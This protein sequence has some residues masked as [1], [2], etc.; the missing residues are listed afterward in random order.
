MTS[1]VQ[2]A[3]ND[4]ASKKDASKSTKDSQDKDGLTAVPLRIPQ[5]AQP[6]AKPPIQILCD[7]AL[8][9]NPDHDLSNGESESSVARLSDLLVPSRTPTVP[10]LPIAQP[11]RDSPQSGRL[12]FAAQLTECQVPQA[13]AEDAP[14]AK[15]GGTPTTEM[16]NAPL[17]PIPTPLNNAPAVENDVSSEK[18][19]SKGPD[20]EPAK[21]SD[22]SNGGPADPRPDAAAAVAGVEPTY[23]SVKS[24]PPPA[25]T[26]STSANVESKSEINPEPRP[27]PAKE[28]SLRIPVTDTTVDLKFTDNAGKVQVSVRS[29]DPGL[30]RS[31]QSGLGDLVDQLEKK[32]FDAETWVPTERGPSAAPAANPSSANTDSGS[33]KQQ[34]GSNAQQQGGGRQ[35]GQ[36]QGQRPKWVDAL[37]FGFSLD[38][39]SGANLK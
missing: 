33:S 22:D 14:A 27:Q 36:G 21:P 34:H 35:H 9:T 3:G 19:P 17:A 5:L 18:Q 23:P 37:E 39:P 16:A 25:P 13:S 15:T 20:K 4:K 1:H 30:A 6:Q 38:D 11:V 2:A 32:G 12:V 29:A 28:I 31:M 10:E 26:V 7:R 24:A 8:Q